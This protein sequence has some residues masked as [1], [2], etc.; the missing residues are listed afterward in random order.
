MN[1][2]PW[3]PNPFGLKNMLGNAAEYCFDWYADDA[4]TKLQDGVLDPKGPARERNM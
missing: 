2:K 4:Y 1:P 3:K